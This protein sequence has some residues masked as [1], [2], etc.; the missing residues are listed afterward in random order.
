VIR[1]G[2]CLS[3]GHL[4][5]TLIQDNRFGVMIDTFNDARRALDR[6]LRRLLRQLRRADGLRDAR[7]VQGV[8]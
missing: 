3:K 2:D 6:H 7:G 8:L 4:A 1:R 5:D